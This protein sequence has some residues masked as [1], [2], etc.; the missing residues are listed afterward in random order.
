MMPL[1]ALV[2]G[3]FTLS[4]MQASELRLHRD[5][6]N[7]YKQRAQWQKAL[8]SLKLAH[9]IVTRHRTQLKDAEQTDVEILFQI[10]ETARSNGDIL[11]AEEHLHKALEACHKISNP[12]VSLNSICRISSLLTS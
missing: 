8:A 7:L 6:A 9:K 2:F 11:E 10:G 3:V 12:Q 5:I 1:I 4:L